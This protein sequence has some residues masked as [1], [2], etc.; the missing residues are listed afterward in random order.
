MGSPVSCART[1]SFS[2]PAR[3]AR[4]RSCSAAASVPPPICGSMALSSRGRLRLRSADP[5]ERAEVDHAYLAEAADVAALAYGVRW[6]LQV[7]RQPEIAAYL[8]SPLR[9]PPDIGDSALDQW[10]RSTHTH[11]WHPA[12]TCRMG[13]DPAQDAVVDPEGVCM[14]CEAFASLTPRY[15]R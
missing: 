12:G 11:I 14:E 2:R 9:F 15:S 4:R 1:S 3:T 10:I 13:P 8:G 7:V 5:G 6:A